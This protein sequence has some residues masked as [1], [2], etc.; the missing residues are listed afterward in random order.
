[1]GDIDKRNFNGIYIEITSEGDGNINFG[2]GLEFT[3]EASEEFKEYMEILLAGIFGVV[4]TDVATVENLGK[5]IVSQKNFKWNESGIF[6][7]SE[8]QGSDAEVIDFLE[9]H[10][11]KFDPKKN[12][13]H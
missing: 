7:P 2:A 6:H 9:F 11:K 5:W 4:S 8:H 13:K 10:S 12:R 3:E 1:M